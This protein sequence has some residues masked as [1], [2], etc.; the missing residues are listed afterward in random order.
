MDVSDLAKD[1]DDD[2]SIRVRLR[3]DRKLCLHPLSQKWC[4]PNRPNCTLND[5]ILIPALKRLRE[6]LEWKLPYLEPLQHEINL[7]FERTSTP[8]DAKAAYTHAVEVKRML[9]FV[10]RRAKRREVTKDW[11]G[12]VFW[13][14]YMTLIRTIMSWSSLTS[15]G[16]C[17]HVFLFLYLLV[18][19]LGFSCFVFALGHQVSSCNRLT[20]HVF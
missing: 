20:H 16:V 11:F 4:E 1:W 19:C 6:H 18:Q 14:L 10:K 7:L 17:W 3:R 13:F 9:S 12:S 5:I 15:G 2:E 8:I